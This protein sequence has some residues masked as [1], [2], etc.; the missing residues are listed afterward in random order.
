MTLNES[1]S[2]DWSMKHSGNRREGPFRS[3]PRRVWASAGS[4]DLPLHFSQ[5]QQTWSLLG[6]GS[7]W[8]P[9][10]R[11]T[12]S[13]HLTREASGRHRNQV[14]EPP[15]FRASQPTSKG[16]PSR[17]MEEAHF[18]G[19]YPPSSSVGHYPKLVSKGEG[20]NEALP[21]RTP[22]QEPRRVRADLIFIH[23]D[24][25]RCDKVQFGTCCIHNTFT[26]VREK[27]RRRTS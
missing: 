11:G 21:M 9:P 20:R 1:S 25:L 27:R 18:G 2:E 22:L 7:S 13:G 16:E 5:L 6:P 23:A 17:P 10:P 19:L 4:P 12:C 14:P 24:V 8:G 15:H 3:R 26:S